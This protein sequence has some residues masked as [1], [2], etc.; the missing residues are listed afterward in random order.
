MSSSPTKAANAA[1]P[2]NRGLEFDRFTNYQREVRRIRGTI[3][4]FSSRLGQIT[5]R[6]RLWYAASV[7][8]NNT[9]SQEI[10]ERV[11]DKLRDKSEF[12]RN[13]SKEQEKGE[14]DW[15]C[16]GLISKCPGL[17]VF[18]YPSILGIIIRA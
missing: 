2:V 7:A 8:Q 10:P 12:G 14:S 5:A 11:Q 18:R 4:P 9:K 13:S 17:Q 16:V 1:V 3:H 6:W 15:P